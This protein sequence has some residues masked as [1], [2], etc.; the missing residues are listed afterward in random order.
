MNT[1][2]IVVILVLLLSAGFA[3]MRGFVRELL[4]IVA[5]VGAAIITIYAYGYAV[6]FAERFL[7]KGPIAN[8]AA[9]AAVFLV[10]LIILSIVTASV[11]GR[12]HQTGM[13]SFDRL[14][15]L[16]F[17]LVRGAILLALAYIALAWY[18]PPDKPRP[19]WVT[20]A[21]SLPLLQAGANAIES[22]IPS[23]LRDQVK[24]TASRSGVGGGGA[25]ASPGTDAENAV[26]ALV[27]PKAPAKP[28]NPAPAY[29]VQ[30]RAEMNRLID[31][32]Q[33]QQQSQDKQ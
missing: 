33:Q 29:R 31:Q 17:G 22:F 32:Q 9:G 4:A 28:E 11:A 26:R 6:P 12:V 21:R 23:A 25:V 5:W 14:F 20:Q 15:G 2:D 24:T 8:I 13:S 27:T 7:P 16:L 1:L 30:D 19:A 10:V 18:L 3:Y